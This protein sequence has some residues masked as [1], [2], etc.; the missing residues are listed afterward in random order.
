GLSVANQWFEERK[1]LF[2]RD[3]V[4]S[5]LESKIFFDDLYQYYKN[6]DT[7][8]FERM[9][10]WVGSEIKKGPLW[11]LKDNCHNIFRKSESKISLSEY[12]F[13]WTLGSIFHEGVK[14]KEDVYQLE[15]Y[16]PSYD[17]IDTSQD[18]EEIKEILEEYFTVIDKA[19]TNLESEMESIN[20][21]FLKASERLRELLVNHS[22]NGLLIRFL[23]ENKKLVDKALGKNST[24]EILASLHPQQPEKIHF[25]AG[26]SYLG[27]GWFKDAAKQ[28]KKALKINPKDSEAKKWLKETEK[29]LRGG[30][31][32]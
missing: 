11:N 23:L 14:L 19:T 2:F 27:G 30:K 6:N 28:F 4:H 9:D 21:L 16:L 25:I 22:H 26:K 24:K 1:D 3:L 32:K 10:F 8:V 5:F 31:N 15:V 7:I 20:Y 29:K 13:D 12:L 17:K 18:T